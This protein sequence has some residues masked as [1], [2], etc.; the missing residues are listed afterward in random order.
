MSTILNDDREAEESV[1]IDVERVSALR[2]LR[3]R[4]STIH[5]C[6]IATR[7]AVLG[8]EGNIAFSGI[9]AADT[10]R[11]PTLAEHV[12]VKY[13][14]FLNDAIEQLLLQG[15]VVYEIVPA[16]AKKGLLYPLPKTVDCSEEYCYRIDRNDP[17]EVV[18][19]ENARPRTKQTQTARVTYCGILDSPNGVTGELRSSLN[20][21]YATCS[22]AES[23]LRSAIISDR[24]RSC[25][26][27][28][29]RIKTDAAF[30]DRELT[31]LNSVSDVRSALAFE[32][33]ALRN[34]IDA[35][36]HRA[37]NDSNKAQYQ[38]AGHATIDDRH[39]QTT[40]P[41]RA[42]NFVPTV[43]PLPVDAEV[44]TY[45]LPATRSDLT[46][47]KRHAEREIV[48]VFGMEDDRISPT[49]LSPL[50]RDEIR[51]LLSAIC[52]NVWR[53]SP[54]EFG[55]RFST[56]SIDDV[57]FE[58][59][60]PSPA[61]AAAAAAIAVEVDRFEPKKRIRRRDPNA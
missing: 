35:A 61:P 9:S 29:T 16:D 36:T 41:M 52:K 48:H 15:F 28:L 40:D 49:N 33:M 44:A 26:P 60:R 4:N 10:S 22:V 18:Y 38:H 13:T 6:V 1:I 50:R 14:K 34:E 42:S 47:F 24:I 12:H 58:F 31:S 20:A 8:G 54:P 27:V 37:L 5:A 57:R 19:V 56:T 55:E 32:N 39:A 2:K 30:D 25:P 21:V 3:E 51:R 53:Q 43:I 7:Q 45:T 46:G 59:P 17:E 11:N 23:L